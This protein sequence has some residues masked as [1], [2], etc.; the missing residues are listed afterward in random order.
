MTLNEH[1]KFITTTRAILTV[2]SRVLDE[3]VQFIQHG[4][5]LTVSIGDGEPK[6]ACVGGKFSGETVTLSGGNV[7]MEKTCRAWL[8]AYIRQNRI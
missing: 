6:Q 1:L 3:H 7:E 8:R 4:I 5:Y 2:Y